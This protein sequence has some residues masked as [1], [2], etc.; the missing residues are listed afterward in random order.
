MWG[1][2]LEFDRVQDLA[3]A[4]DFNNPSGAGFG[5]HDA[6]ICQRLKGGDLNAFS[7]VTVLLCGVIRPDDLVR[8]RVEFDDFVAALLQHD[9]AI[10]Q[11]M[12]VMDAPPAGLPFYFS[13]GVQDRQLLV[14]L[15]NDPMAGRGV[16]GPSSEQQAHEQ[17]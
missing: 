1:V 17:D 15:Q 13:L 6:A 11:D 9:M 8:L 4:I 12:N 2:D 3:A 5:D 16:C 7:L 10:G 14:A